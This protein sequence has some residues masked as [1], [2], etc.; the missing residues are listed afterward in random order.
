MGYILKQL[1]NFSH[2]HNPMFLGMQVI[3]IRQPAADIAGTKVPE[4]LGKLPFIC[5]KSLPNTWMEAVFEWQKSNNLETRL[6]EISSDLFAAYL[7]IPN[8]NACA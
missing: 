8:K 1:S 5:F 2:Q 7:F 6:K 4:K 3:F